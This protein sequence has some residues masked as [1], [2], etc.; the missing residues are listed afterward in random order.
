M[1]L[2]Q[3][4]Y[5]SEED[6]WRIRAFLREVLLLNQRREISWPVYRFDY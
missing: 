2:I 6:I 4:L 3:R 1:N 5:N